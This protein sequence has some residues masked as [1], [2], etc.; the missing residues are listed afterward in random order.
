MADLWYWRGRNRLIE[1][2]ITNELKK[3]EFKS[4]EEEI[5]AHIG[6]E[7]LGPILYQMCNWIMNQ[8]SEFDNL[9]FLSR[10]GKLIYEAYTFLHPNEKVR[11]KYINVSRKSL[12]VPRLKDVKSFDDILNTLVPLLQ[13]TTVGNLISILDVNGIEV[14]ED[15]FDISLNKDLFFLDENEKKQ[16]TDF[17]INCKEVFGE[18]YLLAEKYLRLNISASNTAII[19]VGWQGT[20]QK[21]IVNYLEDLNC[22]G[23][24]L[25][26]R[27]KTNG[28]DYKLLE[29][30]GLFFDPQHNKKIDRMFRFSTDIIEL[31]FYAF[32]GT[33]N[34]YY[35]DGESIVPILEDEEYTNEDRQKLK[36]I[37][38]ISLRIVCLI[39][40]LADEN[41]CIISSDEIMGVFS[42]F[43]VS[44]QNYIIKYFDKFQYKY[45]KSEPLLPNKTVF[46]YIF[47]IKELKIFLQRNGCKVFAL[48][49][50][51]WFPFPYY[52]ILCMLSDFQLFKGKQYAYINKSE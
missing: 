33:T 20:M 2:L 29:R 5:S 40:N 48:K 25:G 28:K 47:H 45:I 32:E 22:I 15:I 1:N 16:I 8:K 52:Q 37:R 41:G 9:V 35:L 36:F 17:V 13:D 4:R 24:Y 18:Q 26:Y 51:L 44:P 39:N 10:E 6:A 23:L 46:Y 43:S 34:S 31:L 30:R 42:R 11:C 38:D 49:K 50:L 7:I 14:S 3:Y 19:D 27:D 12:I 21:E